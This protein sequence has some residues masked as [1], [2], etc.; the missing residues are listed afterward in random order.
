MLLET[1]DLNLD[2]NPGIFKDL[3][4][5]LVQDPAVFHNFHISSGNAGKALAGVCALDLPFKFR[6]IPH[7]VTKTGITIN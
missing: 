4:A 1:G 2:V 5:R 7:L 3:F 6:F